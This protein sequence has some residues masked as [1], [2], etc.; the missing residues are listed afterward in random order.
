MGS[1]GSLPGEQRDHPAEAGGHGHH[2][3]ELDLLG[4]GVVGVAARH[5]HV[6]VDPLLTGPGQD[7]AG[8]QVGAAKRDPD[9]DL[10]AGDDELRHHLP[11][12][13]ER[14]VE[15]PP[16][17]QDAAVGPFGLHALVVGR[18]VLRRR[19]QLH[20]ASRGR[21]RP[22]GSR[23]PARRCRPRS[24]RRCTPDTIAPTARQ[25]RPS[26]PNMTA[27]TDRRRFGARGPGV[28]TCDVVHRCNVLGPSRGE[29]ANVVGVNPD[30]Q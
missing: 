10:V 3:V 4:V 24:C 12:P 16:F 18:A 20:V 13:E 30:A 1:F 28:V 19:R 9:A 23:P 27:R 5:E 21:A 6:G 17:E 11:R 2:V 14:V 25:P 22:C 15:V 29:A 8:G 7:L 26:A